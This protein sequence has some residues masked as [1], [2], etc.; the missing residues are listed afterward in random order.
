MREHGDFRFDVRQSVVHGYPEHAFNKEGIDAY[1]DAL[2][3]KVNKPDVW[4]YCAHPK[5][6]VAL[7]QEALDRVI[8]WHKTLPDFG[9]KGIAVRASNVFIKMIVE[10]TTIETSIP[11]FVSGDEAEL[12]AFLTRVLSSFKS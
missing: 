1:F 8:S 11:Y 9:C 7:N 6:D 10:K 12:E 4:V 5:E 2:I 3:N